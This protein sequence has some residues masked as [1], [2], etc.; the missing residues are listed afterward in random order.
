MAY[1]QR[2]TEFTEE[3]D[4]D[5]WFASDRNPYTQT[6]ETDGGFVNLLLRPPE[7]DK[8]TLVIENE[9]KDSKEDEH[10]SA[11]SSSSLPQ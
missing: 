9:S 8:D 3:N 2:V 4:N 11:N 7:T 10:D 5:L 6:V 1:F